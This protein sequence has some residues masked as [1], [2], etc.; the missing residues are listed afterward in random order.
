MAGVDLMGAV[1]CDS[2]S[3]RECVAVSK[4]SAG[5]CHNLAV[6]GM[7]RCYIHAGLS[8]EEAKSRG[9]ANIAAARL[10]RELFDADAEAIVDPVEKLAKFGGQLG[11]MVDVLGAKVNA[12][13]SVEV[14]TDSGSSQVRA[15]VGL[16]RDVQRE[17][18]ATLTDLSRLG[19]EER[20]VRLREREL[21]L[22]VGVIQA[23]A[24]GLLERSVARLPADAGDVL[25]AG[26][27]GDVA[28]VVPSELRRLAGSGPGP[29]Q[30]PRSAANGTGV[31]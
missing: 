5:R 21:E 29:A 17:Y 10:K 4:R 2:H 30:A 18:R 27:A 6:A 15:V 28:V 19:L 20:S 22:V 11:H 26:W 1:W 14:T 16:F 8:R 31:G 12:L 24:A 7:P 23:V 13:E 25:R 3:R 9:Q